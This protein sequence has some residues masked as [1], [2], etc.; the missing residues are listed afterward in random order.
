[1]HQNQRRQHQ[2]R[3]SYKEVLRQQL[4]DDEGKLTHSQSKYASAIFAHWGRQPWPWCSTPLRILMQ[5][6]QVAARIPKKATKKL[7]RSTS[8]AAMRQFMATHLRGLD[9]V[10]EG[11][12]EST[13]AR[14][15]FASSRGMSTARSVRCCSLW[16]QKAIYAVSLG[17]R[18]DNAPLLKRTSA[19]SG[20]HV[21]RRRPEDFEATLVSQGAVAKCLK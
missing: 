16:C 6:S 7:P 17:M 2:H 14:Q 12:S 21:R 13:I 11:L 9:C 15:F 18:M 20:R 4:L 3:G 19:Q 10:Y 5:S 8:R 1:M